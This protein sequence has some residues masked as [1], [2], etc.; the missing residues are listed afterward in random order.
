MSVQVHYTVPLVAEIDLDSGEVLSV[1]LDDEAIEGPL[2][3]TADGAE[4]PPSDRERAI[5]IAENSLWP[6]WHAGW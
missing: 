1:H 5:R 2:R 3:A 4:M 6:G